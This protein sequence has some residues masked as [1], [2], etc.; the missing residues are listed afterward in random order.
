MKKS[1]VQYDDRVVEVRWDF[2]REAWRFMRMR[3]DKVDGNHVDVV[4]KVVETILDPVSQ[5]DVRLTQRL[6]GIHLSLP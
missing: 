3:D 5:K 6:P 1:R 2:E 4:E